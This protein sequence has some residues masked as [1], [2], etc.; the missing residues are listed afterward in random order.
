MSTEVIDNRRRRIGRWLFVLA[1]LAQVCLASGVAVAGT[2]TPAAPKPQTIYV[3][4]SAIDARTDLTATQKTQLKSKLLEHIR[5]N[6]AACVG[7]ANVTVTN[8]SSKKASA[9][10]VVN[11]HGGSSPSSSWGQWDRG[12][13]SVN[14]YLGEFLDDA[15]V[16]NDFKTGGNWDMD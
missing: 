11:I 6:F 15:N 1:L 3:D 7:S 16:A 5:S 13:K 14:I 10:R 9:S 4:T 8:D 12:S 2:T